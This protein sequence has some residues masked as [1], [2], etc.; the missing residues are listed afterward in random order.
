LT[1]TEKRAEEIILDLNSISDAQ[2]VLHFVEKS[3]DDPASAQDLLRK[4]RRAV[5]QDTVAFVAKC[6][7]SL[8]GEQQL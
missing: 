2:D 3:L 8:F 6:L 5:H 1:P 7:E 4:R